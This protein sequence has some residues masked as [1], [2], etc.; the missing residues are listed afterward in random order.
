MRAWVTVE[1]EAASEVYVEDVETAGSKAELDRLHVHE[2]LV[3]EGDRAG[4]ARVGDAGAAV[5]LQ[6]DE[7]VMP[8]SHRRHGA[9]AQAKHSGPRRRARA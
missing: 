7:P 9:L 3:P 5:H 4:H 1:V 6:P 2:H 8:L